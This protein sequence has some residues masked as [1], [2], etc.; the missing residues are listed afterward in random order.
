MSNKACQLTIELIAMKLQV[1]QAKLVHSTNERASKHPDL[2][3]SMN[4]SFSFPNTRTYSALCQNKADKNNWRRIN[5]LLY[6]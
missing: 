3:D 6:A 4:I 2:T 5:D 1:T